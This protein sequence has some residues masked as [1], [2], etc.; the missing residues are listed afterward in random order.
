MGPIKLDKFMNPLLSEEHAISL[1]LTGRE[2]TDVILD[3]AEA[4]EKFNLQARR[5]ENNRHVVRTPPTLS[6]T[7][8]EYHDKLSDTWLIPD[9]Y[10][11]IDV[12]E[13]LRPKTEH[14]DRLEHEM[15]IY[16][17]RGMEPVLRCLIYLVDE[18]RANNVVWG[19]GRGSSVASYVLYLIGINRIDPIKYGL[20]IE[21]FLRG[22]A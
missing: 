18:M 11:D 4:A 21:E 7:F 5:L 16:R 10:Q 9:K 1:L 13:Y 22:D 6:G 12:L 3:D 14:V 17:A 20:K 2:L 8:E 19:V 15:K